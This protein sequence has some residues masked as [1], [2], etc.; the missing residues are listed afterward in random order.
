M[1]TRDQIVRILGEKEMIIL[2]MIHA[3]SLFL[4][5]LFMI[6]N[7]APDFSKYT[8]VKV[9]VTLIFVTLNFTM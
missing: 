5:W 8:G 3:N 6:V 9:E 7:G 1:R 4:A 2:R